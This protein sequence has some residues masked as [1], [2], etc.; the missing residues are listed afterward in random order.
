MKPVTR[1]GRLYLGYGGFALALTLVIFGQMALVQQ[2]LTIAS[3]AQMRTIERVTNALATHIEARV[4]TLLGDP[5]TSRSIA[6]VQGLLDEYKDTDDVFNIRVSRSD[7]T[8]IASIRR[9]HLGKPEQLPLALA[10]LEGQY[11][12]SNEIAHGMRNY[13]IAVPIRIGGE[14]WGAVVLYRNLEP[15]YTTLQSAKRRIV[16][17]AVGVTSILLALIG[18]LSWLAVREVSLAR[19]AEARQSRLALMGTMAASVAHE[20]RNPLN[21]LSLSIEYL[22][23]LATGAGA[24]ASLPA[25]LVDDLSLMQHEVQRL[26]RVARDFSDLAKPP[27]IERRVISPSVLIEHVAAS[28]RHLARQ[29]GIELEV[30]APERGLLIEADP[31]RLEQVL[32][33]L[34]KNALEATPPKGRVRIEAF[35]QRHRLEVQ[36]ADSGAGMSAAQR[37]KIFEP[38]HSTRP[39]GLGLGMYLSKRLVEAHQ[40]TLSVESDQGKG[41]SVRVSLP[42]AVATTTT[43]VPLV[44]AAA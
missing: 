2:Q 39:G 5:V 7:R 11:S 33:N 6:A 41:T 40:G 43:P 4:R 38:F 18:A 26:D 13:C 9:N 21:A 16:G 32:V 24:S 42:L 25:P 19:Q 17:A 31:Q 15:T 36:V 1:T 28:F 3:E 34:V 12:T 22:K 37:Q 20:I 10:A 29:R 35:T 14:L 23:R 30:R 27:R 8:V 44:P